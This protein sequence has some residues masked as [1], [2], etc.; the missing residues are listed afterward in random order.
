MWRDLLGV[1]Q[2]GLHDGFFALGGHSLVAVRLFARVKKTWGVDLPL[3]TLFAAPT[4]EALA[5]R[6]REPLG[7]TLD[8]SSPGAVEHGAPPAKAGWSPLVLIRKGGS[9]LPFFCVHGAGGN[10]LV[11]RD[12]AER[13][14]PEQPVYG[15]EAR[16]VDGHLPPAA[17]IEEM[18]ETVSRGDPRGAASRTRTSSAATPG[19]ESWPSRWPGG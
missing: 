8:A 6:V 9:R 16:G 11:F 12:L 19:A 5:A 4:L 17:S 2:V 14:G 1:E 7:L 15:L 10:L 3:A 13:L 18:A